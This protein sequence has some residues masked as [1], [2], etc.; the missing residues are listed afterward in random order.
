[1]GRDRG[2]G[3]SL[4]LRITLTEIQTART[5]RGPSSRRCGLSGGPLH[6]NVSTGRIASEDLNPLLP[7]DVALRTENV[8]GTVGF[9]QHE[10]M[11]IGILVVG[12]GFLL[13]LPSNLRAL[14]FDVS[15]VRASSLRTQA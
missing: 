7:F 11:S 6:G 13:V 15:P 10:R 2:L 4:D 12:I 5:G 3:L 9:D 1:M 14:D 8:M